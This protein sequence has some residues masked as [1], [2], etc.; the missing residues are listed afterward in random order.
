M[1]F[2]GKD[3]RH[4]HIMQNKADS[5]RQMSCTF[6]SIRILLGLGKGVQQQ[7]RTVGQERLTRWILSIICICENHSVYMRQFTEPTE[8]E[9]PIPN[10]QD[11]GVCPSTPQRLS[12]AQSSSWGLKVLQLV[13]CTQPQS[14]FSRHWEESHQE[15][16]TC[17]KVLK[18]VIY[19]SHF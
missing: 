2:V 11:R 17:F 16:S 13:V 12:A 15:V 6:R 18:R 14:A 3:L 4:H 10:H 19:K 9:P 5:G 1:S 7:E 8:Q